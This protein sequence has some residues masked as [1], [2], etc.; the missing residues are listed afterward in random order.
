MV[1]KS[2]RLLLGCC[3][4][5]AA[6]M[7]IG[8][9]FHSCKSKKMIESTTNV[10]SVGQDYHQ[11]MNDSLFFEEFIRRN[12]KRFEI[13]VT[14]FQPVKDSTGQI[15]GSVPEKQLGL[16]ISE[17]STTYKQNKGAVQSAQ[18]DSTEAQVQRKESKEERPPP[19]EYKIFFC[20]VLLTLLFVRFKK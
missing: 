15:T 14:W 11:S 4:M 7:V 20:I 5:F 10:D 16:K 2:V 9:S 13:N 19:D 1:M 17:D 18:T 3:L 12:Q 6:T 8:L